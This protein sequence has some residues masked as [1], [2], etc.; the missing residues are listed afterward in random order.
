MGYPVQADLFLICYYCILLYV[1]S[2]SNKINQSIYKG[3]NLHNHIVRSSRAF[4][5]TYRKS[6]LTHLRALTYVTYVIMYTQHQCVRVE[7]FDQSG[8]RY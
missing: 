7:T 5:S 3:Q 8:T 6:P 1:G 2:L 4:T